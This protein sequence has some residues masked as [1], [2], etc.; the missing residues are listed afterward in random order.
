MIMGVNVMGPLVF[1]LGSI[2]ESFIFTRL[3]SRRLYKDLADR[4]YKLKYM[5]GQKIKLEESP[6][7]MRFIPFF[8]LLDTAGS[9]MEYNY[10]LDNTIEYLKNENMISLMTQKEREYYKQ[11]PTIKTALFIAEKDYEQRRF[12]NKIILKGD[13]SDSVITYYYDFTENSIEILSCTGEITKL[14][15]D[16]IMEI[17]ITLLENCL[18]EYY[19]KYGGVDKY[20]QAIMDGREKNSIIVARGIIEALGE[21][22][23]EYEN[24]RKLS[25]KPKDN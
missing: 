12:G 11:N 18:Y 3:N 7:Y 10:L 23:L 13:T 2:L 22:D 24:Q 21:A 17:T 5:D 6:V 14:D 19:A 15:A 8:N 20:Y 9:I 4:G 1:W 16:D 25:K